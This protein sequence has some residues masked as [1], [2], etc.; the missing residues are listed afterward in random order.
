MNTK[1]TSSGW[2][3]GSILRKFSTRREVALKLASV[4]SMKV[5]METVTPD[6]MPDPVLRD[7]YAAYLKSH[8]DFLDLLPS[9]YEENIRVKYSMKPSERIR[10]DPF[11]VD[12][13]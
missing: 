8:K 12:D 3:V 13:I 11:D 1:I 9:E 7:A 10:T 4:N 5:F 2:G 6:H